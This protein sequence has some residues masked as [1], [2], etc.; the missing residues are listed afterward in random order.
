[1]TV[2]T[3]STR[4]FYFISLFNVNFKNGFSAKLNNIQKAFIY[5]IQVKCRFVHVTIV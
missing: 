2:L 5:K 1:M 4:R 3:D